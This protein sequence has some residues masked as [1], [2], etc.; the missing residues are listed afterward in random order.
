MLRCDCWEIKI[1][2]IRGV[3]VM[4]MR[5]AR[6]LRLFAFMRKRAVE[7]LDEDRPADEIRGVKKRSDR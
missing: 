6:S 1:G 2:G 3:E 4:G 7:K 5:A